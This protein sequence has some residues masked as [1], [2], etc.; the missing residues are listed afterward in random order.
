VQEHHDHPTGNAPPR[1]G[2][3]HDP[4]QHVPRVE[5]ELGTQQG[6]R[7]PYPEARPL[8]GKTHDLQGEIVGDERD[9]E[10]Q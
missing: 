9:K 5:Q 10:A 6:H 4:H 1:H 3:Q 8:G 2:E 7:V